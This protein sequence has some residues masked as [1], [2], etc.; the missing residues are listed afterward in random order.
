MSVYARWTRQNRP[1]R[2]GRYR[3]Y[4]AHGWSCGRFPRGWYRVQVEVSD[5]RNN[6]TVVGFPVRLEG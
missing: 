6:T 1:N 3:I 4:L 5:T 2:V